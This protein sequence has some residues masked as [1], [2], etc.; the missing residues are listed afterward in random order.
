MSLASLLLGKA[1]AAPDADLD[2][3]FS[4]TKVERPAPS[5]AAAEP[6]TSQHKIA[7][8]Q[9][10]IKQARIAKAKAKAGV[11]NNAKEVAA[12]E[13][14]AI[15]GSRS[16]AAKNNDKAG[17]KERSASDGARASQT[18][19]S[20]KRKQIGYPPAAASVSESSKK[21][22]PRESDAGDAS[23]AVDVPEASEDDED[24]AQ[25]A[26]DIEYDDEDDDDEDQPLVHETLLLKNGQASASSSSSLQPRAKKAAKYAGESQADRNARTTFVGNVPVGCATKKSSK[27]SLVR[28]LIATLP[29][30][31][32]SIA[33]LDS[34]RFRSIQL[35]TP[36][37]TSDGRDTAVA[38]TAQGASGDNDDDEDEGAQAQEKSD[39]HARKRS[40]RWKSGEVETPS[41]SKKPLKFLTAAQKK[42]IGFIKGQVH[43]KASTCIAYIVWDTASPNA[44]PNS[45]HSSSNDNTTT[46]TTTSKTTTPQEIASLV[47]KHGNNTTFENFTL[48]VDYVTKGNEGGNGKDHQGTKT[49]PSTN[50]DENSNSNNN[51]TNRELAIEQKL[52]LEEEKRTLYIGSLDFE[53]KEE[54]I[55]ELCERLMVEERG[56]PVNEQHVN[57]TDGGEKGNVNHR[58]GD[59][60]SSSWV[61]RVRLVRDPETGLGKGF[62]YVMFKDRE[63]VD[64]ML[65]IDSIRVK[66]SKRKLR[67]ERCKTSS[68]KAAA[69]NKAAK[70]AAQVARKDKLISE[71]KALTRGS[72]DANQ[73][74]LVPKVKAAPRPDIGDELKNLSKDE[75]K[76]LKSADDERLA[77][78][79]EK[80]NLKRQS[81]KIEKQKEF[82]DQK[83]KSA[84]G[85]SYKARID[86]AK[87]GMK[88]SKR[89]RSDKAV[90]AKNKKK[91]I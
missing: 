30:E 51:K 75:R 55:R 27:K 7:P 32:H 25:E 10:I 29:E 46:A 63:C 17:K 6:S 59:G 22:R 47:V 26:D 61:E 39:N 2:A 13:A 20:S 53:E 37:F 84:G 14:A 34:I 66:L 31:Y 33:K 35:A 3:V 11:R 67:L 4:R 43:E 50:E 91:A 18:A 82:L 38:S 19:S 73:L 58:A 76:A 89:M 83:I 88:R 52:K 57:G 72:F 71:R 54:A 65:A 64:E 9:E 41:N 21:K 48:R 36:A 24:L 28:H 62:A 80:K 77:R 74:P 1:A 70:E 78:R 86:P 87:E 8:P 69:A 16:R 79:L 5:V 81:I 23:I 49:G 56:K 90:F 44:K 68:A 15:A 12:S 85:S 60:P 40:R 42:K 45:S